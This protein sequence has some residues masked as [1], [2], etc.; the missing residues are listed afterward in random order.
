[1]SPGEF[2]RNRRAVQNVDR[3]QNSNGNVAQGCLDLLED[4]PIQ[5]INVDQ[6]RRVVTDPS[7]RP[8]LTICEGLLI[9]TIY[10]LD[11]DLHKVTCLNVSAYPV[12]LNPTRSTWSMRIQK[13]TSFGKTVARLSGPTTMLT[14]TNMF[15]SSIARSRPTCLFSCM[16]QDG[17]RCTHV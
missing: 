9:L 7:R 5:H 16:E 13:T 15:P 11:T 10:T 2:H 14:R 3:K 12:R 8:Q 4:L 6:L 17:P 1:M